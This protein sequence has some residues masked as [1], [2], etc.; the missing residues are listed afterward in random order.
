MH[1]FTEKTKS[2]EN[3]SR[4]SKR[5]NLKKKLTRSWIENENSTINWFGGQVTLKCFVNSDSIHICIIH[6]PYDL[7]AEYLSIVL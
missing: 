2:H 7:I 1:G 5:T 6:E 4:N 3:W